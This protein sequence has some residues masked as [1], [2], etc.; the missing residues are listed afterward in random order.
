MAYPEMS[1]C[2]CVDCGA[3][4]T[5]D[6]RRRGAKHEYYMV[7]DRVWSA[8]GMPDRPMNYHGDFLCIG[9]LERRL[10]RKLRRRDFTPAL[11]NEIGRWNSDRMN[12]RLTRP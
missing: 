10:G 8:A 5:P 3:E 6:R 11:V 9:C 7:R 4:T 12:D 1:K 2:P